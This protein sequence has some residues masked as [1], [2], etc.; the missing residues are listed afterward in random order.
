MTGMRIL[1]R[2][3]AGDA[4]EVIKKSIEQHLIQYSL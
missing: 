1:L 2:D 3:D 4:Y